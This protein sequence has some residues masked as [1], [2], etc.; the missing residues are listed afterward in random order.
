M[1]VDLDIFEM[2]YL[3]ESCFRGS[4]LRSDTILR[5]VDEWYESFTPEQRKNLY[6]WILRDIY[7]G[8]FTKND[9]LCGADI[10]FMA[11][12]NP[13]NQY[14]VTTLFHGRE[15]TENAFLKDG[16]Y[17]INSKWCIA[18]EYIVSAEKYIPETE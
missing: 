8:N 18:S 9:V 5:F 6:E 17:Y 11:R 2:Y 12:F 3:L 13:D 15:A 14:T 16:K 1:K 4:H 10:I 7:N